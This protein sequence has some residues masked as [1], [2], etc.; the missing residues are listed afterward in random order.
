MKAVNEDIKS[1]RQFPDNHGHNSLRVFPLTT[2]EM[3]RDY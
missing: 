1:K 3:K 2:S